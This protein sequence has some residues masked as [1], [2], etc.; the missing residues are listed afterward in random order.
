MG[1]ARKHCGLVGYKRVPNCFGPHVHEP[2]LA[3]SAFI[4]NQASSPKTFKHVFYLQCIGGSRGSV[5]SAT[6]P[7]PPQGSRFFRFDIQ[8]FRN[9]TAS[10][11][12]APLREILD[13]PLQWMIYFL[14][15]MCVS[16]RYVVM[17]VADFT[18]YVFTCLKRYYFIYL[19]VTSKL[20]EDETEYGETDG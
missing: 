7:P 20:R 10:G 6:T 16:C 17:S 18:K 9:V 5:P 4:Q 2:F 12:D 15:N 11:V 1:E 14:G 3:I 13:P 8:N 19:Q